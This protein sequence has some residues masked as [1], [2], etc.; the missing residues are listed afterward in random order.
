VVVGD[1][2]GRRCATTRSAVLIQENTNDLVA[3]SSELTAR[4]AAVKLDLYVAT[5]GLDKTPAPSLAEFA[6]QYVH[7]DSIPRYQHYEGL[8]HGRD[9]GTV[10]LSCNFVDICSKVFCMAGYPE[11]I[12]GS[13]FCAAD[14]H[15][16][17]AFRDDSSPILIGSDE[18][19][20]EVIMCAFAST[21]PGDASVR[22]NIGATLALAAGDDEWTRVRLRSGSYHDVRAKSVVLFNDK[23]QMLVAQCGWLLG[24]H[25]PVGSADNADGVPRFQLCAVWPED[26][27]L[28]TA[29]ADADITYGRCAIPVPLQDEHMISP[30]NTGV[31]GTV[32]M[33]EGLPAYDLADYSLCG[34]TSGR[35]KDITEAYCQGMP[36]ENRVFCSG[37]AFHALN[38]GPL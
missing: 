10:P 21:T 27:G 26:P 5:G 12:P 30:L 14:E 9:R 35:P 38:K 37:T 17:Y 7:L 20:N 1:H 29:V 24:R 2:A 4:L 22:I 28:L 25:V 16:F 18:Q 13:E 31:S 11:T 33:R 6:S 32:E 34:T 15:S 3:M 36:P 8:L 23:G 19:W